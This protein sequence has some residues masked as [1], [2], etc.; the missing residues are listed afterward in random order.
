M[1]VAQRKKYEEI[2]DFLE[3]KIFTS[4]LKVDDKLPSE[5]D[6]MTQFGAGRSSV[7]EA[8]FALQRKGLVSARAG[9][10][11]RVTRPTA[12]SLV[13]E[14]S[15]A[16]RH[17][18]SYPEGI[19]DL[20]NARMLLEVGLARSA[21]LNATPEDV[22]RLKAALDAN[23]GASDAQTFQ[24]SDMLFHYTLAQISHNQ[25]F[26]AL[27]MALNNWLAEQ[28]RISSKAGVSFDAVYIQ[29]EAVFLAIQ[30]R[31]PIAAEIAME[32]HLESVMANYW[33]QVAGA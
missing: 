4:G 3:L 25:V 21:A 10:A 32:A 22:A 18:L 30:D 2:A 23:R 27:N 11:A 14:L 15:G 31:D 6:L 28:R 8:I 13:S 24:A 12:D 33:T 1:S 19:R 20:Q 26:T 5:R 16:A 29:H 9:T 17:L 7:R